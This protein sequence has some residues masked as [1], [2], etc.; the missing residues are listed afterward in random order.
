MSQGLKTSE[1]SM[2]K[3]VKYR[4][5]RI[6]NK[7]RAGSIFNPSEEIAIEW[8]LKDMLGIDTSDIEKRLVEARKKE[9]LWFSQEN[10]KQ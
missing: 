6:M 9:A 8:V 3:E 5:D 10:I 4:L 7:T 1:K 2:I